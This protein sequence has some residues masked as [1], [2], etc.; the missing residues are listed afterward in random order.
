MHITFTKEIPRD[1]ACGVCYFVEHSQTGTL[2]IVLSF[3]GGE[4]GSMLVHG[5]GSHDHQIVEPYPQPKKPTRL[6]TF[7]ASITLPLTV[8]LLSRVNSLH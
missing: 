3:Q 1:C 8:A 2:F 4:A 5:I 7:H 6:A